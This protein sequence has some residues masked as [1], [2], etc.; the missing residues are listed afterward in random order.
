MFINEVELFKGIPSHI[1]EEIVGIVKEESISEGQVL[2]QK[3][4]YADS[5]FILQ[6]GEINIFIQGKDR[7]SFPVNQPG[8][9][10]GWSAIVE[11]NRYTASA[12]CVKESKVIKLDGD[13]LMR[14]F[15]KH[16]S[17]GLVVMKKLAGVIAGRL[18]NSYEKF[19]M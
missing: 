17:E 6:E 13:L 16:P 4:D 2:F 9:L 12:E 18:L 19:I 7:I 5:L 15:E 14:I 11:P 10:F 8:Q 3:G 1:I